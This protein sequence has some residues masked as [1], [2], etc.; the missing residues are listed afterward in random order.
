MKWKNKGLY[1]IFRSAISFYLKTFLEF[2]VWGKEKIPEGAKIFCSN[3][4]SS[5]DPAFVLTL[6]DEHVHMVIGPG[7]KIP[8][9][10][11]F[12]RKMEHINAL[13]E[14][15]KNVI[16]EAAEYLKKGESVYIF[17][18]GTLNDQN[19]LLEFYHGMAKIQKASGA[20]VVPIG[21]VA[22]KRYVK[23]NKVNIKIGETVHKTM[24]IMTGKYYANIG[25]ELKF[26]DREYDIEEITQTV[27]GKVEELIDDIK[28]NKFWE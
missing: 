6:M 24:L 1:Y 3:H 18:E 20:P 21:I 17:P 19:E 9:L 23:E 25:D 11:F 12:L 26:S 13:E 28:M 10:R 14:N 15:R 27:K 2:K 4:I 5:S 22:P 8:V 16:T 7:F